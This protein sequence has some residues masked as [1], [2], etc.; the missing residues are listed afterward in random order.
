[1]L[2][3]CRRIVDVHRY[4][5]TAGYSPM[6]EKPAFG[7]LNGRLALPKARLEDWSWKPSNIPAAP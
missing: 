7:Q 2:T 3:G 4:L 6:Y 5:A 1:M